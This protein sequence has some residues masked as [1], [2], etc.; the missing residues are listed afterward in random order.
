MDDF[1]YFGL[2]RALHVVAVVL[3]I[4]GVA[5]V[6]TTLIPSLKA[7]SNSDQRLALFEELEGKFAFQARIVTLITGLTGFY[8]LE[9]MN[10][11]DRYLQPQFWWIHMMTAIWLIFTVVLFVLEPLFLHRHF[12][13]LAIENSVKA[14]KLLHNMHKLLLVLSLLTIFVSVAGVHGLFFI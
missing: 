3:W 1:D 13:L 10:A 8:M 11:W 4:G 2:A 12:R 14:F 9:Y 6:T 7:M 5:F